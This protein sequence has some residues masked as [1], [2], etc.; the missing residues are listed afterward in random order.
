MRALGFDVTEADA[1][2]VFNSLDDDKSGTLEYKELN[3]ML[4][5]G[6]GADAT[7]SN[8]KRAPK[9]ADRSRGAK[10]TAKGQNTNY[11]GARVATLPPMVKLSSS[12]FG[13]SVQA[14]LAD[15]LSKHSVKLI[16][17]F[18]EWDDDGNG[19]IDKKE[20]RQAVAALGY[21]APM[22]DIDALFDEIDDNSNGWIEF[23][24]L[25]K[26]LTFRPVPKRRL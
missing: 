17:L 18:R 8:L 2:A 22:A 15:A 3:K 7:A 1:T 12:I 14:Q 9:Q 20:M 25:K 5:A 11:V 19:A 24:E 16:D 21:E 10:L 23:E 6:L 4:R 13:K 26:A